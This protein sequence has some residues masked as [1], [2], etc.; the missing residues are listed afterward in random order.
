MAL[1]VFL[2]R[3]PDMHRMPWVDIACSAEWEEPYSRVL[4]FHDCKIDLREGGRFIED[5]DRLLAGLIDPR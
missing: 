5:F 2:N 1:A 3:S 4:R